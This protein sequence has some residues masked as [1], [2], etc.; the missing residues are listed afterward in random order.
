M[1]MLLI[2]ILGAQCPSH[3]SVDQLYKSVNRNKNIFE[4]VRLTF[5]AVSTA[6]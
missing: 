4:V 2:V 6:T 5:L 3:H 1:K